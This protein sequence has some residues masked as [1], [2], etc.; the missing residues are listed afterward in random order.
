[1][2]DTS[3]RFTPDFAQATADNTYYALTMFPYPSGSG[4]HAWHAS[5]FTINDVA[6]RFQRM[7]GKIVFNPFG[8][9]SFGLPT[10]NYAMKMGKPA[11]QVTEENKAHF[12]KQVQALNISFDY[13][14]ILTTSQADYYKWTQWIFAKLYDAWLAYRDELRV[15]R[16][17][18]CQTVL[19]NDQVVDGKCERCKNEIIQKKMPQ[20]FIKIT[21]YADRLITDLDLID[22]P[23]ETK[24][25]QKNWI[26][27]SEGMLFTAP[28]KDMDMEIQTFSAHFEAC[29][30]DTFVV[31]APEHDL[32]TTLVAWTPQESEV[33]EFC[34]YILNQRNKAWYE[35]YKEIEGIFTWRYIQDPLWNGDLPIR[36]A[37]Y[38]LADYWT[39]IVKCS[40][41]DERDFTFAKKYNIPLKTVLYPTDPELKKQV[42]N[43]EVCY[44]NMKEWILTEPA[45]LAWKVSGKVRK[46]VINHLENNWHATKKVSYKLRDR[47]VS[48]QRYRWSPIPIYYD[49]KWNT[50][51]IPYDELPVKLPLDIE[52]YKPKGK[53]PLEEHP[54]FPIYE[55][56]GKTYLRECDTLDTFMCSSFYF[57]RYPNVWDDKE[58]ITKALA[59]KLFPI[60]L[61][62]WWKEHTVGHLLYSRFVHKFLFDQWYLSSPEPFAKLVH[63]GMVLGTDWRKMGKR[64]GNGKDPLDLVREYGADATRMYL[65]FMGPVDQDKHWNEKSL[66]WVK[67]FLWRV[68]RLLPKTGMDMRVS[69]DYMMASTDD[70]EQSKQKVESV[71]HQTIIDITGDFEKMKYNTAVSKIMILVNAIYEHGI[72]PHDVLLGL[73]KF[74]A[75]FA[76]ELWDRMRAALGQTDDVQF[77][78]RPIADASKIV[79]SSITLPVQINGKVRANIHI[80]PWSSEEVVME[81]AKQQE[82]VQKYLDGKTV[83]KVIYIQDKILNIVVG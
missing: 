4:L 56:N 61:Y 20:W 9:D 8:F 18:D 54:T 23:E 19:A 81:L 59:D 13:E 73:T 30:A 41:H 82:N 49:N 15:N 78:N 32:V 26:G 40:A 42:K 1:M 47:S 76:T 33:L 50:H 53:S 29:Y 7:Q 28:V 51:R 69:D 17:P 74:I 14:R 71:Y 34:D 37:S 5:V 62:T 11:Y 31:I 57:L 6:A 63:Q 55:K 65:M 16:C 45:E 44:T 58:L 43:Q 72:A 64:Y 83:R 36:V 75:L 46:D 38:A 70:Q 3:Q 21:D 68:E 60:D 48:R 39:W 79:Q 27:R 52:N 10:E 22:W 66:I 80:T 25:A 24:I 35:W 67:K 77:G 12:L 2:V